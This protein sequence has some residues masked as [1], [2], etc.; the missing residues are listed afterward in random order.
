MKRFLCVALSCSS[1]VSDRCGEEQSLLPICHRSWARRAVRD[2]DAQ[3]I[4]QEIARLSS[5]RPN[6]PLGTWL[7]DA[8]SRARRRTRAGVRYELPA[9]PAGWRTSTTTPMRVQSRSRP[10]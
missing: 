4:A 10:L 9:D 5:W 2:I 8:G 6:R 7:L 1:V 3:P